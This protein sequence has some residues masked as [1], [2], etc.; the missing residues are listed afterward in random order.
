MFTYNIAYEEMPENVHSKFRRVGRVGNPIHGAS[1]EL[2]LF[3]F[4]SLSGEFIGFSF[5]LFDT[6]YAVHKLFS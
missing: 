2:V 3:Y 6:F 5:L 4:L 1:E